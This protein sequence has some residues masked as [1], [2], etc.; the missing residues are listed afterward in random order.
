LILKITW[1]GNACF[2]IESW[3]SSVVIDPYDDSE[4]QLRLPPLSLT[5]DAVICSH[6]HFDHNNR[7]AITLTGKPCSLKIE[8]ISCFHDNVQGKILGSNLI[9]IVSDGEFRVAHFGDLGHELSKQQQEKLGRLDAMMVNVGGFNYSEAETA[10]RLANL[11]NP[12]VVIPMHY[13]SHEFGYIKMGTLEEFTALRDDVTY[14][15][16]NFIEITENTRPH[17]A[18]LKMVIQS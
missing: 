8:S 16:V 18:A 3:G 9:H 6:E 12:T 1:Y 13:R 15:D 11:L 2:L 7:K 5:A 17:T 10:N 14:Y 4:G